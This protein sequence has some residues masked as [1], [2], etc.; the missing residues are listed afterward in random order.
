MPRFANTLVQLMMDD[1]SNSL[2]RDI[3]GG[4]ERAGIPASSEEDWNRADANRYAISPYTMIIPWDT[5]GKGAEVAEGFYQRR[6]GSRVENPRYLQVPAAMLF[7]Y[8]WQE[9]S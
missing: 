1:G 3:G 7:Y 6:E 5:T 4:V 2:A 9:R 8:E